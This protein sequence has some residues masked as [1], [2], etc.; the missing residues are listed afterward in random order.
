MT[1][2]QQ[3]KWDFKTNG[4]LIIRDKNGKLIYREFSDGVWGKYERDSQGNLIYYENSNGIWAKYEYDSN[5]K[6][7]YFESSHGIIRDNRPKPCEG[8]EIVIGGEKIVLKLTGIKLTK[9]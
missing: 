4:D 5:G 7:I 1:I 3:I 9:V 2:A 6:E 8:K